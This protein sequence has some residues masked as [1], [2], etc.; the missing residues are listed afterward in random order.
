MRRRQCFSSFSLLFFLNLDP[1]LPPPPQKKTRTLTHAR[2]SSPSP[3]ARSPAEATSPPASTPCSPGCPGSSRWSGGGS[4]SR[5]GSRRWTEGSE[6]EKRRLVGGPL[7]P[8]PLG[9]DLARAAQTFPDSLDDFESMNDFH[10]SVLVWARSIE[11]E[12]AASLSSKG[13]SRRRSRPLEEV[14]ALV[15]GGGGEDGGRRALAA[16]SPPSPPPR[17][18]S[19]SSSSSS[20]IPT[21]N[22]TLSLVSAARAAADAG[23]RGK[24]KAALR[25]R[26][27]VQHGGGESEEEEEEEEEEDKGAT[28]EGGGR[29]PPMPTLAFPSQP[30]RAPRLA[31]AAWKD[32]RAMLVIFA[33]SA[34]AALPERAL[35]EAVATLL[36]KKL[37]DLPSPSAASSER[38]SSLL[39]NQVDEQGPPLLCPRDSSVV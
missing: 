35:D 2:S 8:L 14:A 1:P 23:V 37:S 31:R 13:G 18:S 17:S 11:G 16:A 25:V 21:S 36:L 33:L 39:S 34:I 27:Q 30:E 19:S 12:A 20:S 9:G 10:S 24:V 6:R 7:L 32:G 4:G 29:E 38:E 15:G 26:A 22:L 3:S 28:E 5:R